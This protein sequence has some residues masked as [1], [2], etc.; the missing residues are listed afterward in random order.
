M[1]RLIHLPH[2]QD[3]RGVLTVYDPGNRTDLPFIPKRVF[4]IWNVPQHQERANHTHEIC[5]QVIIPLCG[6]FVIEIDENTRYYL[7]NHQGLYVE[8]GEKIRLYSFSK[9]A[10]ALVLCS[11]YYDEDEVIE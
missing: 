1:P 8:A 3:E 6:R 9:G 2:F 10:I 11:E 5:K 4:W 7:K